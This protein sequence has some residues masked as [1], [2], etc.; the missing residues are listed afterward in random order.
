[1]RGGSCKVLPGWESGSGREIP[2]FVLQVLV[3][4]R[5]QEHLDH[6]RVTFQ[7]TED[8]GRV[9]VLLGRQGE[10]AKA[11]RRRRAGCIVVTML[12]G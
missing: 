12:P 9:S 4:A 11:V 2:Y 10:G 7:S 1:M 6:R 3:C 5:L 8:Q